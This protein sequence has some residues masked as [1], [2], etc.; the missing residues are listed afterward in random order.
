M[1]YRLEDFT[2]TSMLMKVQRIKYKSAIFPIALV[3]LGFLI[4]SYY[5]NDYVKISSMIGLFLFLALIYIHRVYR[6]MPPQESGI[7]LAPLHGMVTRTEDNKVTIEKKVFNYIDI[8]NPMDGMNFGKINEMVFGFE[9]AEIQCELTGNRIHEFP[10]E[11]T[12]Q[13]R[14]KGATVGKCTAVI[15]FPKGWAI[16]IMPGEKVVA[17]E[18]IIGSRS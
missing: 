12:S 1:N 8:R 6:P 5:E 16:D 7:C 17:G 4:Y 9:G 15:T 18:T 2:P 11:V 13:G 14:M 10:D 3:V